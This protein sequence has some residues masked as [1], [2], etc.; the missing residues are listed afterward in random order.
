MSF[1]A[2]IDKFGLAD[3]ETLVCTATEEGDS[4]QEATAMNEE[5]S[6]AVSE[7]YGHTASPTCEYAIKASLESSP[8]DIVLGGVTT[9]GEGASAK[10]YCLT[11]VTIQTSAGGVPTV[12]AKGEQVPVATPS[13]KYTIEDGL[14]VSQ[15]CHAQPLLSAFTLGGTG[16]Y[17]TDCSI[18]FSCGFQATTK[19]GE[20]LAWDVS[21]GK[22]EETLSIVRTGTAEPTLSAADGWT[23]TSPLTMSNPDSDF[24]TYEATIV[25]YLQKDAHSND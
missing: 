4:W 13:C 1:L 2:K 24:P 18:T 20:Y 14:A 6:I 21:E 22:I 5:G 19:D 3:N 8:K 15:K 25:K 7:V 12:S 16:C 10:H 11:E 17:L 23:I 9:V